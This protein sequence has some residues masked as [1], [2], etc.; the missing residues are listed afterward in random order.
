[1]KQWEDAST[2]RDEFYCRKEWSLR[3][4]KNISVLR[5]LFGGEG[6]L[7]VGVAV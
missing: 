4:K 3:K 7:V 6:G 5:A 1:M 2:M